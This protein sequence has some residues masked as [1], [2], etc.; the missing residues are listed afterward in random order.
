MG[1]GKSNLYVAITGP[2][3]AGKT[4]LAGR[5]AERWGCLFVREPFERNPFLADFYRKGHDLAL[6]NELYFLWA[7]F[8]QLRA[9]APLGE[10]ARGAVVTDYTFR[11]G[12]LFASLTLNADELALYRRLFDLLAPAVRKPDLLIYLT[13]ST[14]RLLERI[15]RRGRPME[16]RL[17]A[18]YVEPLRQAYEQALTCPETAMLCIDC[19]REDVLA[20]ET[21]RRIEEAA[22]SNQTLG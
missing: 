19:G 22:P 21:L 15:V 9:V 11:Q 10:A 13:D 5:L 4:T 7:R 20:E 12:L 6:A 17:D 1:S 16:Q 8:E 18:G 14:D 2:I 3:A